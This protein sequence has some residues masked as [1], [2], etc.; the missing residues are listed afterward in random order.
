MQAR[1]E[2]QNLRKE[3]IRQNESRYINIYIYIYRLKRRE[4]Y[5]LL[6][7]R[8]RIKYDDERRNE[9][10]KLRD[11]QRTVARE[12]LIDNELQKDKIRETMHQ[13]AVWNIFDYEIIDEA[14]GDSPGPIKNINTIE[15]L[16]RKKAA[17]QH[18]STFSSIFNIYIYIYIY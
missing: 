2:I 9:L 15:T 6:Q 17:K 4:E 3:V 14:L 12:Q 10:I 1:K 13:M 11:E 7:T 8:E 5:R 18:N 16:V